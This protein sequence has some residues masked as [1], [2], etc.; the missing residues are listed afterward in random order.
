MDA[1]LITDRI[2]HRYASD[3][4]MFIT[5]YANLEGLLHE[6]YKQGTPGVKH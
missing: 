4:S 2:L 3:E 1:T 5:G 6:Q